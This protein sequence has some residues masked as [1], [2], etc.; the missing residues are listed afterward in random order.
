MVWGGFG[1]IKSE[2]INFKSL[3][4]CTC[5]DNLCF[6]LIESAIKI[7]KTIVSPNNFEISGG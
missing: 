3:F 2:A 7:F 6:S 4:P 5:R 1:I